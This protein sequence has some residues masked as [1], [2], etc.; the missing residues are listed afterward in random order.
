MV[1]FA[2][3]MID[4]SEIEIPVHESARGPA[5][6]VVFDS[7]RALYVLRPSGRRSGGHRQPPRVIL[8]QNWW[9]AKQIWENAIL[10]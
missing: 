7:A 6:A 3:D 4:V 10:H 5:G 9:Q 2:F 8:D 1:D